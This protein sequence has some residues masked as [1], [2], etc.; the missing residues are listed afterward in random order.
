MSAKKGIW[1]IITFVIVLFL[2]NNFV[3]I[4]SISQG[5]EVR[6]GNSH[7]IFEDAELSHSS[8]EEPP[9]AGSVEFH[10]FNILSI[11]ADQNRLLLDV[12]NSWLIKNRIDPDTIRIY[13]LTNESNAWEPALINSYQVYSKVTVFETNDVHKGSY[14]IIGIKNSAPSPEGLSV[15]QSFWITTII[16]VILLIIGYY[17]PSKNKKKKQNEK[18]H[19]LEEYLRKAIVNGEDEQQVRERLISAGWDEH[20]V[21]KTLDR[22]RYF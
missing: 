22:I 10:Q 2:L 18:L 17:R 1:A 6:L 13:Y 8:K 16:V 20:M 7:N 12:S 14:S 3:D 11:K 4:S 19:R 21:D 9:I 15:K 5:Y